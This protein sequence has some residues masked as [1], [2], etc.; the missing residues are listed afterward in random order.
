MALYAVTWKEKATTANSLWVDELRIVNTEDAQTALK[1][2]QEYNA[3]SN[4]NTTQYTVYDFEK[5]LLRINM[6]LISNKTE[7]GDLVT[8]PQTIEEQIR[9]KEEQEQPEEQELSEE[10]QI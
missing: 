1:N 2:M 8:G 6:K 9:A 5:E 4:K 10:R 3:R 7:D